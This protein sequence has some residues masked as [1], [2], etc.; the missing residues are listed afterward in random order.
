MNTTGP[1]PRPRVDVTAVPAVTHSRLG[2]WSAPDRNRPRDRLDRR[3]LQ[4]ADIV[5]EAARAAL[6]GEDSHRSRTHARGRRRLPGD[7]ATL[8]AEPDE[9]GSVVL[10]CM[11]LRLRTRRLLAYSPPLRPTSR[12]PSMRAARREARSRTRVL[13]GGHAP[14][15]GATAKNLRTI[16]LDASVV[17]SHSERS[18]RHQRSKK[19]SDS[20]PCWRSSTTGMAGARRRWPVSSVPGTPAGIPQRNTR[21]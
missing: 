5:A 11:G 10:M 12:R 19:A 9:Y 14:G 18:S 13:A 7:V 3:A 16:D 17:S 20:T 4:S 1:Y 21:V 15:S 6:S 2:R 8:R